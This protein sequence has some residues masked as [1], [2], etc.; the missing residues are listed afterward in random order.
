[1]F[2][3]LSQVAEQTAVNVSRRQFFGRLGRG[4]MLVAAAMGGLL[5]TPTISRGGRRPPRTCSADSWSACQG[6][7]EGDGCRT[8][9]GAGRCYGPK[10]RGD[11]STVTA[12]AC[13]MK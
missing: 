3:K 2:E 7:L 12:C 11:D 5:A 4:A 13:V 10:R 8:S 1:M 6:A 9:D